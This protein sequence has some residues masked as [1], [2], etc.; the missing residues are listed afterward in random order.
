MTTLTGEVAAS[1]R[2]AVVSILIGCATMFVILEIG[3]AGLAALLDQTWAALIVTG[4]TRSG[5]LSFYTL[6]RIC[7]VW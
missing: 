2:R 5:R 3:V 4:I 6:P 1:P 7:S